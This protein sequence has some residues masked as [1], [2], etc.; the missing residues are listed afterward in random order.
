MSIEYMGTPLPSLNKRALGEV[1]SSISRYGW[2][3][4]VRQTDS[5]LGLAGVNSDPNSM[6]TTSI[7]LSVDNIYIAFHAATRSQRDQLLAFIRNCLLELGIQC[8]LEEL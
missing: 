5:E 2:G 1:M 3:R 6:E 8:D 7:R 4:V